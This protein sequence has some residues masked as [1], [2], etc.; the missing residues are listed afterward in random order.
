M[1][2]YQIKEHIIEK[3][4]RDIENL[5]ERIREAIEEYNN[6]FFEDKN[7]ARIYSLLHTI[8]DNLNPEYLKGFLVSEEIF[9]S[10]II[11]TIYF[12]SKEETIEKIPF[13]LELNLNWLV[14]RE[15]VVKNNYLL[16]ARYCWIIWCLNDRFT[17]YL[18]KC[19]RYCKYSISIYF[20]REWYKLINRKF[21]GG[22]LNQALVCYNLFEE[23]E[24]FENTIKFATDL[25]KR[26]LNRK[27]YLYIL[28]II[29]QINNHFVLLDDSIKRQFIEI[30]ESTK[31]N[32]PRYENTIDRLINKIT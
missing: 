16:R 8:H 24:K 17:K 29:E 32:V 19:V 26:L 11:Q 6:Q 15:R 31:E 28:R 10:G 5:P 4:E 1:T 9:F 23:K 12:Y 14:Y 20:K 25:C 30:L 18:Y 7:D 3:I 27:D 22:H 2:N 13:N 21:L